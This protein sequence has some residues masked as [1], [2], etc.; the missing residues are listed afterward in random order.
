MRDLNYIRTVLPELERYNK[1]VS[2][3]ATVTTS[4]Y[5]PIKKLLT[6]L[7]VGFMTEGSQNL[8]PLTRVGL[9][10]HPRRQ[11][12][13][14]EQKLLVVL[15]EM[16]IAPVRDAGHTYGAL[17]TNPKLQFIWQLSRLANKLIWHAL[18]KNEKNCLYM[19]EMGFISEFQDQLSGQLGANMVLREL[20]LDNRSA[21]ERLPV[22]SF[23]KWVV[24]IEQAVKD[25]DIVGKLGLAA[26]FLVITC[27]CHGDP[28]RANQNAILK[29]LFGI[30]K[31]DAAGKEADAG[32]V[33]DP[34]V[35]DMCVC[36]FKMEKGS[37][38][39][40]V[41]RVLRNAEG[42]VRWITLEDLFGESIVEMSGGVEVAW[43]PEKKK[44]EAEK[45]EMQEYV[46]GSVQLYANLCN[47]NRD[48]QV[49]IAQ[50]MPQ[51]LVQTI[52]MEPKPGCEDLRGACC[53][54]LYR[55]YIDADGNLPVMP[56]ALTRKFEEIEP[57]YA[58]TLVL[59]DDYPLPEIKKWVVEFLSANV[60]P[61]AALTK[62]KL[63]RFVVA[64][65]D[66]VMRLL[67]FGMYTQV[68]ELEDVMR[69]LIAILDGTSDIPDAEDVLSEAGSNEKVYVP[70]R[71][72]RFSELPKNEFL[73]EA[74]L[75]ICNILVFVQVQIY[76]RTSRLSSLPLCLGMQLPFLYLPSPL[77]LACSNPDMYRHCRTS[78]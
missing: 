21:L 16:S 63:N 43:S 51:E 75:K 59:R 41:K 73:I 47:S 76:L 58:N 65:I 4:V 60:T 12:L 39:I 32:W 53:D 8:D 55:L 44:R 13:L 5:Q 62:I 56:T 66:L 15:M 38:T 18:R 45:K 48:A 11:Q 7:I 24:M 37:K 74:K 22:L 23:K 25:G 30:E 10:K 1:F 70:G 46:V 57:E 20:H 72:W 31:D 35:R 36:H 29:Y 49:E 26:T 42:T 3:C 28:I 40:S 19:I 14:R 61:V 2:S 27:I 77:Q 6:D 64:V 78:G 34:A 50:V 17:L 68:R 33:F 71:E 67:Q 52:I 69:P 54:L 9:I